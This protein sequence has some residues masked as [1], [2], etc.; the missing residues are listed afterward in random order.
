MEMVA[1]LKILM[2]HQVCDECGEG[3]MEYDI[4][5]TQMCHI[6]IPHK[7]DRC[8][9]VKGFSVQYPYQ[10]MVPVEALREP[11]GREIAKPV[12]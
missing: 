5:N 1:E 6:G 2:V 3:I 10:R 11:V 12:G 7:C 4:E 8:G 9:C